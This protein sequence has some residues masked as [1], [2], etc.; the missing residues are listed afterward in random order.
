MTGKIEFTITASSRIYLTHE[1][2]QPLSKLGQTS[3]MLEVSRE[4]P[5][6]NFFEPNGDPNEAGM[7]AMDN[8]LIA[9]LGVSINMGEQ[10]GW[11]SR[12]DHLNRLIERLKEIVEHNKDDQVAPSVW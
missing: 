12:V 3:L 2:G 10:R 11:V 9:G 6:E 4:I 5:K 8:A 1:F 7:R